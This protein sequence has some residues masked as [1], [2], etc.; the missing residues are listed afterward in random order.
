MT[1]S[2]DTQR[3]HDAREPGDRHTLYIA[4]NVLLFQQLAAFADK[5]FD[6]EQ[7][8]RLP[9]EVLFQNVVRLLL[10]ALAWMSARTKGVGVPACDENFFL[11]SATEVP[12]LSFMRM[13]SLA[14]SATRGLTDLPRS[15]SEG[16]YHSP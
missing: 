2:A 6:V 13:A 5:G 16:R 3:G 10:H 9:L 12:S 14:S 15:P 1:R 4:K 8:L 7:S 11:G